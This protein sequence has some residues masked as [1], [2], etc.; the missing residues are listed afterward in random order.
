MQY[1]QAVVPGTKFKSIRET[2]ALEGIG[3]RTAANRWGNICKESDFLETCTAYCHAGRLAP[4]GRLIFRWN[5][6]DTSAY[7]WEIPPKK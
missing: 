4:G 6:V 7:V 2:D 1:L 5:P 3:E